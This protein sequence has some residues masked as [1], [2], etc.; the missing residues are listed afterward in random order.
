[1]TDPAAIGGPNAAG[2]LVLF[3]A[4]GDLAYK[5]LFPAIYEMK[6]A[7]RLEIPVVGVASS[8]WDTAQLRE[9]CE[10]SVREKVRHRYLRTGRA[11]ERSRG[12]LA[13]AF[14]VRRC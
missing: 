9:R 8:T 4:T 12:G 6:K 13:S 11:S 2:V 5:K 3:G 7:G 1:M 14:S 10:A